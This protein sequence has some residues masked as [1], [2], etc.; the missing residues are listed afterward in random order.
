VESK[1]IQLRGTWKPISKAI[2]EALAPALVTNG[3]ISAI[4]IS[5]PELEWKP[6]IQKTATATAI[7]TGKF[8][9]ARD[10]YEETYE[11]PIQYLMTIS[12][13]YKKRGTTYFEGVL[14]VR[15]ET[16]PVRE[17]INRYVTKHRVAITKT[18]P[19]GNGTDYYLTDHR[20]IGHLAQQLHKRFGGELK[21]N[22][23]HFSHDKQRSKTLY[24]TT[25]FVHLPDFKKGDVLL[26]DTSYLL[27]KKI[28]SV[29][30]C[31]NLISGAREHFPYK[32][33]NVHVL[34]VAETR[35]T[36]TSPLEVL[37]PRTFAPVTPENKIEVKLDETVRVAM[38]GDNVLLIPQ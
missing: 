26:K 14:Q 35:V 28:D 27:V 15:N 29:V 3:T 4:A 13:E 22:A 9:D 18:V 7:I 21:L 25:G 23:Q 1:R 5:E 36:R 19:L 10:E 30:T 33:G 38:D 24:R 12:P 11:I 34:P 37:H 32:P 20:A 2:T 6:G 8:E 16:P 31:Q 17:E